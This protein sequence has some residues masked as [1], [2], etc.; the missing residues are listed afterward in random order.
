MQALKM[1]VGVS[2]IVFG[3]DFPFGN[4][5]IVSIARGLETCGFSADELRSIDR[6]NA[7]RILP[8]FRT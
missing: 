3:S 1:L 6:E 5:P 2:Q 7:L 8:R 4:P